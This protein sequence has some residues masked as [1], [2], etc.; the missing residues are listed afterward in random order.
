MVLKA[1]M[2]EFGRTIKT[3]RPFVDNRQVDVVAYDKVAWLK[4]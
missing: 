2:K 4:S 1:V 3:M